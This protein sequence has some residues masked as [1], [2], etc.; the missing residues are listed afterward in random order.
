MK[1]TPSMMAAVAYKVL[2]DTSGSSAAMAANKFSAV[3]F[4][5]SAT[6]RTSV[7]QA[8]GYRH[9]IGHHCYS[10]AKGC[11]VNDRHPRSAAAI[12]S[13]PV[14]HTVQQHPS[15]LQAVGGICA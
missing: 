11:Y 10:I 6:C 12:T 14:L 3:S 5:P 8:A 15:L 1:G 7:G 9:H 13:A 2:G 4:R